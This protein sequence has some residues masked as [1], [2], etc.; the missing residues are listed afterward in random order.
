M[1]G[2]LRGTRFR[3]AAFSMARVAEAAALF[4]DLGKLNPNFQPKVNPDFQP[5][6]EVV[7]REYSRHAYLS[8][9][10]F[11][12]F[13]ECNDIAETLGLKQSDIWRVLAVIAHHHGH[14]PDF[15]ELLKKTECDETLKF[16]ATQP[17]LPASDFLAQWL[18]HSSFDIFDAAN[19][20]LFV[21]AKYRR[22]MRNRRQKL[23]PQRLDYFLE[24][25]FAF[26]SLIESDKRDAGNNTFFHRKEQVDWAQ[27]NFKPLLQNRFA[28]LGQIEYSKKPLNLLRTQMR[29]EAVNNLRAALEPNKASGKVARTFSLTAPTGAG[30]TFALL[31]LADVIREKAPSHAVVYGLPFLTITE[32]VEGV[33]RGIFGDEFVSRF[34]SRTQNKKLDELQAK[35]DDTP[36][37]ARN[38]ATRALLQEAFSSETFDAAFTV[39]TF[40]EIFETLLSNRNA[41]LLKLPNFAKT[42]FLLDEIQALPP[43]LYVFFAA[44]LQ[45]FCEKFD[46]Y[47]IFSTATMPA[48]EIAKAATEAHE[49]FH[50]YS[51]PIELL[52]LSH[53]ENAIFDRYEVRPLQAA[54]L[55]SE[56]LAQKIIQTNE[57]CLVV[58]NTIADS[59]NIYNLL[60]ENADAEV[61]LLNTHF[62]LRDRQEKIA[63]CK[64]LL[65]DSQSAGGTLSKAKLSQ[66]RALFR[67]WRNVERTARR[68]KISRL[69]QL[70]ID[71]KNVAL[72]STQLIE[73]GVDIDFPVV[74]RD[75]CP[76]PSVIQTAG[77]CNRNGERERGLVWFFE[78]QENGKS[79]AALI[80]GNEPPWFL[81]FSREQILATQ[82]FRESELL[83]IQKS[84][85][86]KVGTDLK[87]GQ[88]RLKVQDDYQDADLVEQIDNLAFASVGSF[89]L[90]NEREFGEFFR[91]F[92]PQNEDGN[93]DRFEKLQKLVKKSA[94]ARAVAKGKLDY[95]DAKE[96]RLNIESQLRR[97]ALDIVQFR[98]PYGSKPP[99]SDAECCGV[100]RLSV[101]V[102]YGSE[103]GIRFN[104]EAT[105]IL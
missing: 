19:N 34:D 64:V 67:L 42:I 24:T 5:D 13:L 3:S 51:I 35:L 28:A 80:Y 93:E 66:C 78:L 18:P 30:K 62:T 69:K 75:L 31:A 72:V 32:Q 55:T 50:E 102:D 12:C 33:C 17:P 77:R 11:L 14:L 6:S 90:I 103:K 21:E 58:L 41:T 83:P 4:H 100:H 105:A 10:A 49:L 89:Q 81:K 104:G 16:I 25:Q 86:D 22:M 59:K 45:A 91:F 57:S 82:G 39:T 99:A 76:L 2:V 53:F 15:E 60:R 38:D 29:D 61:I 101:R 9:Y 23:V 52:S 98:V 94:Q 40:V 44:Y 48:F 7:N 65:P 88:H 73:A 63:R 54:P 26:A 20:V 92:V 36:Q 79:R 1:D 95:K 43:R 84:Y 87:L 37:E 56:E 70:L 71:K 96:H 8:A 47:A 68:E 27:E 85:F 97:M 74:F 46:S